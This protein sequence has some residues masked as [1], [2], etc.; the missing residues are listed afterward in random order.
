MYTDKYMPPSVDIKIKL[1]R[2]S[3]TFGILHAEDDE[4]F[5]MVLKD[6]KLKMRKVLP[7]E[8]QRHRFRMI[9]SQQPCY[10]PFKLTQLKVF[11]IPA[12]VT[13]YTV[14]NITSQILPKQVIFAL[15]HN[16]ALTHDSS[17]CRGCTLAS[18]LAAEV[19]VDRE[20]QTL[21]QLQHTRGKVIQLVHG[22][23]HP[24]YLSAVALVV[25]VILREKI[26]THLHFFRLIFLFKIFFSPHLILRDV[27][28]WPHA[29]AR[30]TLDMPNAANADHDP[31]VG[32]NHFAHRGKRQAHR[33]R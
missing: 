3:P 22:K 15:I 33:W 13:S 11:V 24:N 7:I 6:L 28:Y 17:C 29:K 16:Q 9:M 30:G 14:T 27:K 25:V 32:C 19:G 18:S 12:R 20:I 1:I 21:T 23:I 31:R 8:Q 5:K 4:S 26:L 2:N 10:I